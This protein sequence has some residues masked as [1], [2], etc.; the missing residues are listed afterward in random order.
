MLELVDKKIGFKRTSWFAIAFILRKHV[1]EN[2]LSL[3]HDAFLT[4]MYTRLLGVDVHIN[5]QGSGFFPH[6]S[7]IRGTQRQF[8]EKYLFGRRF[9]T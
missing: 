1:G 2:F 5:G 4:L 9:E 8:S 3:L 6:A 7:P